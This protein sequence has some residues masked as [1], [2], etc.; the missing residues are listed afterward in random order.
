MNTLMS[1]DFVGWFFAIVNFVVDLQLPSYLNMLVPWIVPAIVVYSAYLAS[2][3]LYAFVMTHQVIGESNEW[4]IIIRD[5]KQIAAGVGLNCFRWP[6]DSVAKFPSSVKE[7]EFNAEQVTTEM[8]GINVA[9]TLAWTIYREDDGPFRAYKTHGRELSNQKPYQANAKLI[10]MAQSVVREVI[11]NNTIDDI[12]KNR[13][14]II[15]KINTDLAPTLKGWGMWLERIDIKDVKICSGKLFEDVQAKFRLEQRKDAEIKM[16]TAKNILE[17]ER[18]KREIDTVKR[19]VDQDKTRAKNEI[20]RETF[21]LKNE[22]DSYKQD[23]A[24]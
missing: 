11:A 14:L 10:S 4:V 15:N 13:D 3:T 18:L 19:V 12:I 16:I 6:L 1:L 21:K 20:I 23:C 17:V 7:V 9:A 5:G 2:K 8:Q 24:L 22:K